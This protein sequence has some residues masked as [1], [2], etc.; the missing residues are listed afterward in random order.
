VRTTLETVLGLPPG[1]RRTEANPRVTIAVPTGLG[2]LRNWLVVRAGAVALALWLVAGPGGAVGA[3][4]SRV[5]ASGRSDAT[6]GDARRCSPYCPS[7]TRDD[8]L[9]ARHVAAQWVLYFCHLGS[10][11]R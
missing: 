7:V 9:A 4:R 3:P 11:T 8:G 10:V 1:N 5:G 2:E 6:A